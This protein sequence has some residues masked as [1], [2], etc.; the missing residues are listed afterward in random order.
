MLNIDK[1]KPK[2][3]T[4]IDMF[5]MEKFLS[6]AIECSEDVVKQI[7][8]MS[9]YEKFITE[10]NMDEEIEELSKHMSDAEVALFLTDME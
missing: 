4:E 8:G 6:E 2:I 3:D 7:P 9:N 10:Y 1:L 5:D